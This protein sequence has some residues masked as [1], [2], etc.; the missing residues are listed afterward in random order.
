MANLTSVAVVPGQELYSSKATASHR[1]GERVTDGH[2]REFV[3]VKNGAVAMLPGKVYQAPAEVTD[4]DQLTPVAAAIGD[5]TVTVALGATAATEGQYA[6]GL[7]C[8]DTTPAPGHSYVIAGHPAAALSTSVV[9][10]LEHPIVHTALTTSSRIT[11]APNPWNGVIVSPA[12]TLTGAV[13][14]VAVYP[15]AASEYGWLQVSGHCCTLI[16][17]TPAVGACVVVP[18]DTAGEV[19]VDPANAATQVVGSMMVTGV[20]GK[21]MP[22]LLNIV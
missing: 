13:V 19:V 5:K 3:Y 21:Y 20:D 7:L 22:V 12:T 14:G 8:V 15:L 18:G 11:L 6:G 2:G 1:L 16:G 17:G 4:H 9:I 10:T